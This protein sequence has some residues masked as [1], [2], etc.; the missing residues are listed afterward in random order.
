MRVLVAYNKAG[1][2]SYLL[3][4]SF[5]AEVAVLSHHFQVVSENGLVGFGEWRDGDVVFQTL[6][7]EVQKGVPSG[8][9]FLG[10]S[11][12]EFFGEYFQDDAGGL[13]LGT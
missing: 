9:G 8:S 13:L 12:A 5:A 2:E 10:E 3:E 1:V 11:G 6:G 7:D 4:N